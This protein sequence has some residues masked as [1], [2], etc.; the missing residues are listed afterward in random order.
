MF[1]LDIFGTLLRDIKNQAN[2]WCADQPKATLAFVIISSIGF[3]PFITASAL[4]PVV[5]IAN[6]VD[7]V[8][9]NGK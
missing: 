9:E 2:L 7:F 1:F 4:T 8:T 3:L 6:L 5:I